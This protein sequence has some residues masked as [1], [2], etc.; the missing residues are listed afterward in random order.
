M[1]DYTDLPPFPIAEADPAFRNFAAAL[2]TRTHIDPFVFGLWIH[3]NWEALSEA[4]LLSGEPQ[5]DPHAKFAWLRV[6]YINQIPTLSPAPAV[7]VAFPP[8][9]Q[10]RSRLAGR[11]RQWWR[12]RL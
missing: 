6:T 11:L 7:T 9:Q 1:S 3:D 12:S 5:S 8:S 2:P 4:F 10:R